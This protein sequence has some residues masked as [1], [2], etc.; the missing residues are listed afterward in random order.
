MQKEVDFFMQKQVGAG[1]LRLPTPVY[2][3]QTASVVGKL[4]GEGPIGECFDMIC[5]DDQFGCRTWEEAESEMQKEALTLALGKAKL[6]PEDI[7]YIFA[8]DLLGQTIASSFGVM[9]FLRPVFGLY[10]ACSTIGEAL[11]LG[12]MT[13][14]AGYADRVAAVTSSHFAGAERQ[15]RFPIEYAN[16]R[17]LSSTWTVTGS[18]AYVLGKEPQWGDGTSHCKITEVTTGK[19]MDLG[20]KDVMNMGAAMAPAAAE[21][22]SSH[23]A[24]FGRSGKD[25]DAIITG[26]LGTIGKEILLGLCRQMGYDIEGVHRDC[27]MTIYDGRQQHTCAGGS[28]CGCAAVTMASHFLPRIAS[29]Q[30]KRVLFVPTG[31]LMSPVSANEGQNVPGIAHGVV[32]EHEA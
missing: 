6:L 13:V 12:A 18:G 1:S 7:R 29:G 4:E 21:V 17:P 31:A 28:G 26:D 23:L 14:S 2:I 3:L 8:G 20:V 32:I 25:Y 9:H 27:G 11:S 10:G 16:Q 5:E 15:F 30:W 19:I 24:D 22:I